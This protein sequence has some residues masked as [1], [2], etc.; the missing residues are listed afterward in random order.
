MDWRC[1]REA[2]RPGQSTVLLLH[3]FPSSSHTFRNVMPTLADVAH[4][5]APDLPGFEKSSSPTIDKYDYTFTNLA[6]TIEDLPE[7]LRTLHPPESWHLDWE[8][9][10]RPATS[11]RSS[12]YSATT[13]IMSPAS[14]SSPS[15]TGF[16]SRRRSCCGDGATRS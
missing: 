7:Y 8:R 16:T 13:Q 3:G 2:G 15:T 9:M 10:T 1:F 6:R 11:T 12:R 14:M 4:M 5:I